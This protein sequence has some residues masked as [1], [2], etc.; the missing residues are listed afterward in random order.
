MINYIKLICTFIAIGIGLNA[1]SVWLQSDFLYKFLD[2]NL[3]LLLAALLAI[4]TTTLSVVMTKMREIAD[5]N[6]DI[7][8]AV[9]R[10]EMK[11]SFLEQIYLIVF[12]VLFQTARHSVL[13]N[14]RLLYMD[15]IFDSLL[16]AI[17][18]HAIHVVYDTAMSVFVILDHEK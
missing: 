14:S 11:A 18:I 12:A 3:I 8:F 16:V 9:T 17:F 7:N 10:K 2:M 15:F 13:I 5:K 1:I 4:N 6:G